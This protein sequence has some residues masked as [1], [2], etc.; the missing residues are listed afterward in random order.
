[1]T[2]NYI[3]R[4]LRYTFD[5]SDQQMIDMW[6]QADVTVS[7]GEVSA[8]LK[9][10]EDPDF[11]NCPDKKL[12]VFLNGMINTL[13][14]K[15]EGPQAV[16]ESR[17]NNNIILRK[18]K[19]ALN[20][21]DEDVCSLME[22]GGLAIGKSELSAFFRKVG[23]KHYRELQDQMLRKFIQGLQFKHRGD[24]KSELAEAELSEKVTEKTAQAAPQSAIKKAG[25]AA[26]KK[27]S[28]EPNATTSEPASEGSVNSS[29]WN[30]TPKN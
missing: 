24:K 1:M 28:A 21:R 12:A 30:K 20:L 18:L 5:Y 11:V 6:A 14:G 29:I 10:D 26:S 9:K 7:R 4:R 13:R 2:N 27:V 19:I 22:Q 17:L 25:Q 15:K 8:W 3:L 23:H 16:A